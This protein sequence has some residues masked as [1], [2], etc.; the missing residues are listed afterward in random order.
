MLSQAFTFGSAVAGG[1]VGLTGIKLMAPHG[2]IF[3]IALTSNALLYLVFVLVGAIVSGV[4]YGYLRKP[5]EK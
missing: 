3:V 5:L 2:G 1:L 4:V